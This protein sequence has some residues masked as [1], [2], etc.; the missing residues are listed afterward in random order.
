MAAMVQPV[1][2]VQLGQGQGL[3]KQV[4]R[5]QLVKLVQWDQRVKRAKWDQRDQPAHLEE[6]YTKILFP[7][8]TRILILKMDIFILT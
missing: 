4:Q 5:D 7:I 2:L 8:Q 3:A 1:Q 6:L